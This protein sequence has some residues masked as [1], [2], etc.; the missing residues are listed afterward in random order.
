[1]LL[2]GLAGLGAVVAG[3]YAVEE[4]WLPGRPLAYDVL[5]LNGEDGV[6]PEV[7]PGPVV[8]GTL[9]SAH[10]PGR[11]VGWGVVLPPGVAA[12]AL[13]VVVALHALGGDETWA[14]DLGI[15]RFLAA[16]AADGVAPFA[17][18][19]VAGGTG[20]WHPHGGEDAGAM[21]VDDLLPAVTADRRFAGLDVATLGM[22]GWSMG[23]Y[24]ALRL[25][26]LLG[27]DRVRAV[28]AASPAIWSD[29]DDASSSGF[30][31]AAEYEASSVV[32][33]QDAL[34]GIDVRIDCGKGDPFLHAVEDYVD[35]FD[36]GITV[37]IA[38]GG[39][40]QGYWRRV[41]PDQLRFLGD[42]L[43]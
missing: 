31:D 37:E 3:G 9:R 23:G 16:A 20:Y 41:L 11:A 8:Y 43:D 22:I 29:P 26:P 14:V 2:G 25:A 32:G 35:G 6:V 34:R 42:A 21:V 28:A 12:Q 38:A 40:D 30:D 10:V 36:G 1:L 18:V 39:H 13:P 7:A 24:G 15:D 33:E 27:A 4:D 19:T 5:G 17:V